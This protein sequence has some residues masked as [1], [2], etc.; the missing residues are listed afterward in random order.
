MLEL[1]GVVVL[2]VVPRHLL[3]LGVDGRAL[4]LHVGIVISVLVLAPKPLGF[5]VVDALESWCRVED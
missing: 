2:G 4:P 5:D 3:H 1:H